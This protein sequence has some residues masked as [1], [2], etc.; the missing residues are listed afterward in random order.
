MPPQNHNRTFPPHIP[1]LLCEIGDR[2]KSARSGL[3][4]IYFPRVKYVQ[5]RFLRRRCI[6]ASFAV[7]PPTRGL[8]FGFWFKQISRESCFRRRTWGSC[9]G[10]GLS[11]SIYIS[12][13]LY[14]G[15]P[16]SFCNGFVYLRYYKVSLASA[17][18]AHDVGQRE[19]PSGV[20]V[21]YMVNVRRAYRS[22]LLVL[23]PN[24]CVCIQWTEMNKFR[25]EWPTRVWFKTI[26]IAF[27]HVW[28]VIISLYFKEFRESDNTY[29]LLIPI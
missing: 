1:P 16:F 3:L 9:V 4:S 29:P 6:G 10:F 11:S 19:W 7:A 23:L 22:W 17:L 26:M 12:F 5:N 27:M 24:S 2:F 18:C 13:G 15:F 21:Y 25:S 14:M 20:L 8:S 28:E